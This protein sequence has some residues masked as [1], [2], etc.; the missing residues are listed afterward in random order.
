MYFLFQ[1]FL[2]LSE[3]AFKGIEKAEVILHTVSSISVFLDAVYG[4]GSVS[5]RNSLQPTTSLNSG[6]V[7]WKCCNGMAR[8]SGGM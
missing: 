8:Y 7:Y 4:G 6:A 2:H 1:Q 3:V 5:F